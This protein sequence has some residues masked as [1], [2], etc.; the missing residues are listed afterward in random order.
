MSILR[1][2]FL[3]GYT[4]SVPALVGRSQVG[5][6]NSFFEALYS[7]GFIVGPAVAGL[8]AT[9]IGP[10]PTLAIDAISFALS[11]LGLLFVKRDLRA[12]IDRPRERLLT[13]VREGID[14][15]L[16]HPTL[17]IVIL[18][19][20]AISILTAPLVSAL[21]VHITRDLA[22]PASILGVILTAY[23][24][25]TVTG[26]L[27]TAK[28]GRHRPAP[29]LLGGTI[30]TGSMLVVLASDAPVPGLPRFGLRVRYRPVHGPADLHHASHEPVA[31]RAARPDR[32]H[33]ANDLA[34]ACNRSG[35]WSAAC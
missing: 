19:W 13:E 16:A 25:G 8:L 27:V 22:L 28:F 17:R 26:A 12:P 15:I 4:A 10:G 2:F 34:R 20:G 35:S 9:T 30:V 5:R 18:F 21:A 24:G 11:G 29:I 6:A 23:G 1:S 31:G 33:G 32:Q 3:A 14:F 7:V